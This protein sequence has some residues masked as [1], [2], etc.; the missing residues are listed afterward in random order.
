MKI[1]Y[2]FTD[3]QEKN[4]IQK[5]MPGVVTFMPGIINDYADLDNQTQVVCVFVDSYIDEALLARLPN[6][7]CI[8]ARS[9][10]F[11][12]I[13]LAAAKKRGITVCYAPT[14]ATCAVA[15]FTIA[16]MLALTRRLGEARDRC[17]QGIFSSQGLAGVDV[18]GK[19]LGI[20]G[21]GNIGGQVAILARGLGMQVIAYDAHKNQERAQQCGFIFRSLEQ[22]LAES[23]V[24]SLHVAYNPSTHHLINDDHISLFKKGA[25][26]VNTARGEVVKTETLVRALDENIL[27]GVALDVLEEEWW[28]AHQ[29]QAIGNTQLS[30]DVLRRMVAVNVLLR[31]PQVIITPHAAYNS[32]ESSQRC[33]V[34]VMDA[35]KALLAGKMPENVL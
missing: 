9:I 4:C 7:K 28:L 14:Y 35:I 8:I 5:Q 11:N 25:Y 2:F 19:T 30:A 16:L 29:S 26:L 34:V 3:E 15:E 10:G 1:A 13:D 27:A 32:A 18:Y 31:H 21:A 23:D 20:I 33:L 12:H 24:V 17:R 22:V 6:L